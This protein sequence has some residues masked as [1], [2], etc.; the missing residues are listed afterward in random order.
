MRLLRVE[1]TR[2][3][4]R[5]AV[6]LLVAIC[7][8]A[9]GAMAGSNLWDTR[10]LTAQDRA[11][12]QSQAD[13]EAARPYIKRSIADCEKNP[14]QFGGPGTDAADCADMI[15]PKA[16]WFIYRETLSLRR[17]LQESGPALV[18]ILTGLL[19]LGAITFAGADWASGSMSNQ[20][21]FEPRR[22]RIWLAKL[23]AVT[24]ASAV[25][26]ALALTGYWLTL[27]VG[28]SMRDISVPATV[29]ALARWQILRGV[30]LAAGAALGGYALTMLLR[31]TVGAVG[32]LFAYS[33][34]GE[35]VVAMLPIVG[36]GRFSLSQNTLAWVMGGYSFW[37]D[38]LRCPP[39]RVECDKTT[40]LSQAH[41]SAFLAVL[42]VLVTVLSFLWYRRRDIA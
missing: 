41:G 14:R 28:A 38:S 4:S 40:Y 27:Y 12:A 1:L 36:A 42:L 26:A 30:G 24:L 2:F 3:R 21:L 22:G 35:I 23:A 19:M 10:P 34:G 33:V 7:I 11:V 37:D 31:S 9:A 39:G 5:R 32:V 20:L 8:L 25:A 29:Q 17:A 13:R 6:M 15:V 18:L 16:E